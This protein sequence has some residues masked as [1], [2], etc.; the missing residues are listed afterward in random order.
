MKNIVY[1]IRIFILKQNIDWEIN[2]NQMCLKF[3][4]EGSLIIKAKKVI[5][6]YEEGYFGMYPL[7]KNIE[8]ELKEDNKCLVTER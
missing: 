4:K 6:D 7:E 5:M 1:L 3:T 2:F 8:L